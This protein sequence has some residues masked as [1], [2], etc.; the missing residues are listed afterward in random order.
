M[1]NNRSFLFIC[2]AVV[3]LIAVAFVLRN[4]TIQE[5]STSAEKGEFANRAEDVKTSTYIPT[6]T[7]VADWRIYKNEQY[8]F[9]IVFSDDWKD[10]KIK[11][12]AKNSSAIASF[13][14]AL[15]TQDSKYKGNAIPFL[16]NIYD[17]AIDQ[18]KLGPNEIVQLK[19]QDYIFTYISWEEPPSDL[20]MIT[21]KDMSRIIS[22][23]KSI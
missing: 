12:A 21:E 14:V 8:K 9:Q 6:K 1:K 4:K 11:E 13:E 2:F 10:Y 22:S 7:P 23:L 18:S 19:T 17:K 16:I 15:P 5:Q 20:R 3:A